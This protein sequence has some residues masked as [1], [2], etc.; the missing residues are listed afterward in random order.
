[1]SVH[2]RVSPNGSSA[3]VELPEGLD[4]YD[5]EYRQT[6]T[7]W[8]DGEQRE[9]VVDL[10]VPAFWGGPQRAFEVYDRIGK[11]H[12]VNIK[13]VWQEDDGDWNESRDV[14]PASEEEFLAWRE[15]F[16]GNDPPTPM[17]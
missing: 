12:H 7:I 15:E 10:I 13:L 9:A 8:V 1:M 16:D 14:R 11:L 3:R 17:P 6:V 2:E 5:L 4:V